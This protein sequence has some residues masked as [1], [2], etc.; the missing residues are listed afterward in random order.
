[1]ARVRVYKGQENGKLG[2]GV[3]VLD[4]QATL[5]DLLEAWQ[6]LCDDTGI[7]KAYAAGNYAACKGCQVNCCKQ[8]YVV[9]DLVALLKISSYLKISPAEF[10]RD[11]LD[12]DKLALGIPRLRTSPCIF[13]RE[14]VC[15]IYP[16]RTLICRFYLCTHI[17]GETEEL[18]YSITM[19]GMVATQ[20]Y[21]AQLGLVDLE[22]QAQGITSYEQSFLRF[23]DEYRD[24][25]MV[26]AFLLARDYAGIPLQLFL[27]PE[28]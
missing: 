15:S 10:A 16:V 24:T 2:V 11:Y 7:Y 17:L 25:G 22:A 8:A 27:S 20:A 13:L 14:G 23:F 4:E 18:I 26:E 21:L 12:T 1:M 9:P 19:A 5:A 3:K 28:T 6:P